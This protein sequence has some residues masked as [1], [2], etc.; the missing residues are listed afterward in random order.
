MLVIEPARPDRHIALG[1]HPVR[2]RPVAAIQ[3]LDVGAT[4]REVRAVLRRPARLPCDATFVADPADVGTRVAEQHRVRLELA[5]EL[6]GVGPL[7]VA[8]IVDL[9][10]LVRAA[11][12]AVAAVRAVEEDLEHR[13][14]FG[15]QLTQLIAIVHEILRRAVV[16]VISV[17]RREIDAKSQ[18][19]TA[20]RLRDL[21]HR[22]AT[23][24]TVLDRML[25]VSRRPQ[26]EAVVVLAGEDQPFHPALFRRAHDLV[27]IEVRW[28][29]HRGRL[30][31]VPP[32]A[33]RECVHREVDK[34]VELEV[35]PG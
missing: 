22:V 17:P 29:E 3:A 33:V 9:A 11:V 18:P 27:G 8:A 4:R 23:E 26:A 1:G 14:V 32:L 19:L 21:L 31:A 30:V 25:R 34:A 7:V 12:V 2:P 15:E 13:P 5:H 16:L 20:A 6:P 28:I 35:V 24:G 10:P